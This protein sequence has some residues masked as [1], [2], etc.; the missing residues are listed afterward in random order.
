VQYLVLGWGCEDE[1][2]REN[3]GNIALL[4]HSGHQGYLPESVAEQAIE[5]Y[6]S[7]RSV[8][9]QSQLQGG[10]ATVLRADPRVTEWKQSV[11]NLYK[12]LP[13]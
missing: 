7:L 11:E 9:H 5:T 6:R 8:R 3:T 13:I 2:L 4:R 1:K 10:D 12:S